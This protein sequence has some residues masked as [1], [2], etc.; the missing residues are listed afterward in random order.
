MGLCGSSLT[1]NQSQINSSKIN[2]DISIMNDSEL[3]KNITN[4]T[5]F[6]YKAKIGERELAIYVKKSLK[7]K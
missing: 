1:I 5:T 3:Q 4:E 2:E 6:N 7:L